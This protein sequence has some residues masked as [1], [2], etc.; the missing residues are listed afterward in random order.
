[1]IHRKRFFHY[2]SG[3]R[4]AVGKKATMRISGS[5]GGGELRKAVQKIFATTLFCNNPEPIHA[6]S[7]EVS[8]WKK[9]GGKARGWKSPG[10]KND[11][12]RKGGE[13][14]AVIG[15]VDDCTFL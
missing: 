12:R 11:G 1:M 9:R 8:S 15:C 5:E 3:E 6:Q 14:E 10:L 4:A 7:R 2:F 13:E